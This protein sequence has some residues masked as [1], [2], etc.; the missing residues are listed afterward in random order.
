MVMNNDVLLL[1]HCTLA[2]NYALKEYF[3]M[4]SCCQVLRRHL[5]NVQK[6]MNEFLNETR[7]NLFKLNRGLI[8]WSLAKDSL[9]VF[10][11]RIQNMSKEN[12]LRCIK[13]HYDVLCK[14]REEMIYNI[15]NNLNKH[16]MIRY[17]DR[18]YM[19]K[20]K[21]IALVG[22]IRRLTLLFNEFMKAITFFASED[23]N[24]VNEPIYHRNGSCVRKGSP[25]K[26]CDNIN[27]DR[28]L[29]TKEIEKCFVERLV[30]DKLWTEL[31]QVQQDENHLRWLEDT[32]QAYLSCH[33]GCT[34]EINLPEFPQNLR[35]TN[36]QNSVEFMKD[37][38]PTML[39]INYYK[40]GSLHCTETYRKSYDHVSKQYMYP[41]DCIRQE[42]NRLHIRSSHFE[43]ETQHW[44]AVGGGKTKRDKKPKTKTK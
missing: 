34:I 26:R 12:L 5:V 15:E 32:R 4:A 8:S 21:D 30:C 24:S 7:V 25:N 6:A 27:S 36:L 17:R 11:N 42:G 13:D 2:K 44:T 40:D 9:D 39:V 1:V 35:T 23:R 37:I 31:L 41:V 14:I 10:E 33:P 28:E 3:R 43:D 18:T 16:D 29:V 19:S 38:V 22:A 20:L